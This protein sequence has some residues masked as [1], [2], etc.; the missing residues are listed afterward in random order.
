M[1]RRSFHYLLGLLSVAIGLGMVLG[2]TVRAEPQVMAMM[3]RKEQGREMIGELRFDLSGGAVTGKVSIIT[4]THPDSPL[5]RT[6]GSTLAGRFEIFVALEGQYPGGSF[7]T[8]GGTARL[9][10][11]F[12]GKDG[13]EAKV[14]SAGTF[15]GSVTG[16]SGLVDARCSWKEVKLD[17][18]GL[19]SPQ[20]LSTELNF[21]FKPTSVGPVLARRPDVAG[22]PGQTRPL[23]Q[24][25]SAQRGEPSGW[26]PKSSEEPALAKRAAGG[27]E[28]GEAQC[29]TPYAAAL[30]LLLLVAGA[31]GVWW[32]VRRRK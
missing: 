13:G 22:L 18:L 21:A 31:I 26:Q 29:G 1:S 8:I 23:G 3:E 16:P 2:T 17:G 6:D 19:A 30:T 24:V 27:A 32:V 14:E 10:G 15:S 5:R 12:V 28:P 25:A 9:S 4:P 7:G 11:K 20:P